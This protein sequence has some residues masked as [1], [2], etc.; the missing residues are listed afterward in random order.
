LDKQDGALFLS[1]FLELD[2]SFCLGTDA[3]DLKHQ[4]AAQVISNSGHE[5]MIVRKDKEI[6]SNSVLVAC[7]FVYLLKL[8]RLAM[9][10]STMP[11]WITMA[12]GWRPAHRIRQ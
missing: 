5:E 12:A 1:F 6:Y 3:P 11:A 8:T 7:S 2:L 9:T 10:R 4:A